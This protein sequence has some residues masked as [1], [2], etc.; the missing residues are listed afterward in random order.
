[1]IIPSRSERKVFINIPGINLALT[2]WSVGWSGSHVLFATLKLFIY[3][4]VRTK[5]G[6]EM[7]QEC[8]THVQGVQSLCFCSLSPLF[9]SVFVAVVVANFPFVN[10]RCHLKRLLPLMFM[11]PWPLAHNKWT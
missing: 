8:K 7:Y 5:T 11:C 1:M 10:G 2:V 9:C 4:V 3:V 6:K